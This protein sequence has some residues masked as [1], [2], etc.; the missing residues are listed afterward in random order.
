MEKTDQ[1]DNM[2]N[3][4]KGAAFLLIVLTSPLAAGVFIVIAPSILFGVSDTIAFF[5]ALIYFVI[6]VSTWELMKSKS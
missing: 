1:Q 6:W 3:I 2:M 5:W 4:I